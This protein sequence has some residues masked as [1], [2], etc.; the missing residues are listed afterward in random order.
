[1]PEAMDDAELQKLLF[2][3]ASLSP[4]VERPIH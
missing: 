2:P 1:L 4:G 3:T